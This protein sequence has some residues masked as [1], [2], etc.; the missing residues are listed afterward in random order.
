MTS[1]SFAQLPEPP[2]YSVIFSSQRTAR[3]NG[4]ALAAERML[5]LAAQQPGFLG[6]ESA[7]DADGFGITVS[8]W[9]TREAIAQWRSNAEH[10]IAQQAGRSLWYGRYELRIGLVERAYGKSGQDAAL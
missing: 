10:Q 1:A 6:V 3:D 7:R 5:E 9:A 2:Y 8:Y 4:Y